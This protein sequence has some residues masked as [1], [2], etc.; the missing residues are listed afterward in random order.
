[1]L[2]LVFPNSEISICCGFQRLFEW[3]LAEFIYPNAF[4]NEGRSVWRK[5]LALIEKAP[6]IG[7]ILLQVGKF[8]WWKMIG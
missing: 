8:S 4:L 5:C 7:F 1:M 3:S 6:S 2:S